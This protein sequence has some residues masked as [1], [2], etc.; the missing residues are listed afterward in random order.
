M[1]RRYELARLQVAGVIPCARSM[2]AGS[3]IRLCVQHVSAFHARGRLNRRVDF[4]RSQPHLDLG[5][6]AEMPLSSGS[7]SPPSFSLT[8]SRLSFGWRHSPF[9]SSLRSEVYTSFSPSHS[10]RCSTVSSVL[11]QMRHDVSPASLGFRFLV[12]SPR[13]AM[14]L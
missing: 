5:G 4:F 8:P 2:F 11:P 6:V 13:W 9:S 7:C 10:P 14:H 3:A 12:H 1:R